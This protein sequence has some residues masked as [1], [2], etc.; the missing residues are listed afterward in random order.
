ME[1]TTTR[2]LMA[3]RDLALAQVFL[4]LA[5]RTSEVVPL[6]V[7]DYDALAK[8]LSVAVRGG[9]KHVRVPSPAAEAIEDWIGVRGAEP[10]PLFVALD[11]RARGRRVTRD[12]V[13]W[14]MK[15]VLSDAVAG[16]S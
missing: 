8:R 2:S 1:K 11:N 10:G 14:I 9:A 5:L 13:V 12:G 16:E 15:R 3:K 7:G 6:D 4:R